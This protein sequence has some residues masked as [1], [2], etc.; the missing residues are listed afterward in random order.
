MAR[1]ITPM[2]DQE[3][4]HAWTDR[5]QDWRKGPFEPSG[6][7]GDEHQARAMRVTAHYSITS[8]ACASTERGIVSPI[9]LAALRLALSTYFVGCSMGRS[10][11]LAPL[12]IR[13]TK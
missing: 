1:S 7:K 10:P 4:S 9:A 12:R 3:S 6:R 11:G 13:S 2:P 5:L 8:S